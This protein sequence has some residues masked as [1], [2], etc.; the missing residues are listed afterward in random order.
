MKSRAGYRVLQI[1]LIFVF[2]VTLGAIYEPVRLFI[3]HQFNGIQA[4]IKGHPLEA[5]TSIWQKVQNDL[6]LAPW[7][8]TRKPNLSADFPYRTLVL[9][10][11]LSRILPESR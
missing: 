9:D 8:A 1:A 5:E 4:F 10:S 7:R 6:G 11:G 3:N 2:G